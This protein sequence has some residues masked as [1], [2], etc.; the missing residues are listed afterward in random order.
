MKFCFLSLLCCLSF[1]LFSCSE[2]KD[3]DIHNYNISYNDL[4]QAAKDFCTQYFSYTVVKQV[5][6]IDDDG[7]DLYEVD[8]EDGSEVIFNVDGV[9]QEV[10]APDGKTI[11]AG[12][13]LPAIT[14]Y[15]EE[16]YS[17][18]GINEI[19]KTGYGFN[20]E[21]VTGLGLMFGPEGN[22][23]QVESYD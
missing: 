23:L 15:L 17:G 3:D 14:D 16:Y 4:P 6:K 9:W 22:F 21:L 12:I 18:Y 7:E 1:A 13:A 2:D 8:F 5:Q 11:P 10:D 20:V 19:N